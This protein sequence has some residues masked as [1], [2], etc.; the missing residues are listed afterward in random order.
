MK[1][2]LLLFF[3]LSMAPL[4]TATAQLKKPVVNNN[5]KPAIYQ[6]EV[7]F[8]SM[9]CGTAPTDFLH[10]FVDS[11]N[12]KNKV[13]LDAWQWGGC[14]KEGEN[15]V[16]FSTTNLKKKQEKKFLNAIKTLIPQQNEKN[17]KI[18]ASMG[19][20]NIDYDVA[21]ATINNCRGNL[22]SFYRTE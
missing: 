11:F 19:E 13:Q 12:K 7:S 4:H 15:I 18:N 21:A 5:P 9:C 6:V 1:L 16:L 8:T 17:K 14:G 20:I 10:L 3:S 2:L 22:I